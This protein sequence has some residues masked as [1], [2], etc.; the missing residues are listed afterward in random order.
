[1]STERAD[2]RRPFWRDRSWWARTGRTSAALWFAT[3]CAFVAGVLAARGLGVQG[4]GSVALAVATVGAVSTFLDVSLEEAI[5]HL[6]SRSIAGGDHGALRALFRRALRL[7][8]LVGV[9]VFG[10]L[11]VVAGPLGEVVSRQ[12]LAPVLLRLAAVESLAG[13]V[14]GTTG[15]MLILA[16]RPDLRAW[17][18]AVGGMFRVAAV[19]AAVSIGGPRAVLLAYAG[20]TAVGS[21]YEAFLARRESRR[22]WG[23]GPAAPRSEVPARRLVSFGLQSSLTTSVIALRLAVVSVIL[24]RS[25]GPAGVGVLSVALLPVT[26]A[27]VVS[28]PLRV[29]MLADQAALAAEGRTRDLWRDVRTSSVAGLAIGTAAAVA[30]WFLLPWLLP[31]LYGSEFEAAVWPARVLL[32]AAIAV[33]AVAWSKALPAAVGR[34]GLRTAVS[35][36]ELAVTAALMVPLADH[37]ARGAAVA[38]SAS[39]ILAACAWWLLAR[40]MLLRLPERP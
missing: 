28:A 37:G 21:L 35:L 18:G 30:G 14:N 7:D 27:A 10:V 16:G 12:G 36:G 34:P 2:P 17:A 39:S 3:A 31:R 5:V 38:I 23:R 4:Y 19:A 9:A 20:S 1:M 8:V 33:L 22:R 32:A 11:V 26:L 40:R 15:G 13:T 25:V 29:A 24:G 6:G